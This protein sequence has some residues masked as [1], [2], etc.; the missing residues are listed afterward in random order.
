E[1]VSCLILNDIHDRPKSFKHLLDFNT[2]PYEFVF[3]NGDMFDYQTDENQLIEH[4]IQPCTDIF[5]SEKPFI[6]SRGNHE[7]RGKF[8][9]AIKDYFKYPK[10]KYD[11]RI[12]QV[13]DHYIVV[14]TGEHRLA[15]L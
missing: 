5:A 4:L 13:T 10:D 3:L 14:D 11:V 12:K 1:T 2:K 9:R 6:L 15:D 7:T 8:A